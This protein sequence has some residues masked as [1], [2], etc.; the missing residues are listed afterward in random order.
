MSGR[1][2]KTN[3]EGIVALVIDV[4]Q[5][6]ETVAV[7]VGD[8][9]RS[10]LVV[11][12]A[13]HDRV[14]AESIED[15]FLFSEDDHLVDAV[16]VEVGGV[17]AQ[18][19]RGKVFELDRLP[20]Q[21]AQFDDETR[22][23]RDEGRIY[24]LVLVEPAES[25]SQHLLLHGEVLLLEAAIVG[26]LVDRIGIVLLEL[27]GS[28]VGQPQVELDARAHVVDEGEILAAIAIDV[29]KGEPEDTVVDLVNLEPVKAILRGQ[30]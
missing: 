10:R 17:E 28:I 25:E 22:P 6:A 2:L 16:A 5:I 29:V 23:R 3:Y 7:E 13:E 21:S 12:V 19:A 24:D 4:E 14:V 18:N 9:Q 30:R 20:A 27:I 26:H 11:Q 15:R 1:L 8:A